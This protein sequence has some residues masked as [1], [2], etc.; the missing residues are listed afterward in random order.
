MASREARPLLV[1][2]EE[3][4]LDADAGAPLVL[5]FQ[6]RGAQRLHEP[7]DAMRWL[8]GVHDVVRRFAP[9][10]KLQVY[11]TRFVNVGGEK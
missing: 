3:V 10:V 6:M 11:T 8:G 7:V 4:V 2:E 1:R 9:E 5:L